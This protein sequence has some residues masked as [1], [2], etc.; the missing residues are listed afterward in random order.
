MK[1][2]RQINQELFEYALNNNSQFKPQIAQIADEQSSVETT[3]KVD[4]RRHW[5]HSKKI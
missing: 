4:S 1:P 2:V 5:N 3:T